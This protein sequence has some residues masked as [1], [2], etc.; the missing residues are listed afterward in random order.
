MTRATVTLRPVSNLAPKQPSLYP[1]Q[2]QGRSREAVWKEGSGERE[3]ERKK[4]GEGG[5]EGNKV[6]W[7][8]GRKEG[9]VRGREGRKERRDRGSPTLGLVGESRALGEGP[10]KPH[11]AK[12]S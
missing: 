9:K 6:G 3:R 12:S 11:R 4:E 8:E 10:G 1:P 2:H 7:R 5:R